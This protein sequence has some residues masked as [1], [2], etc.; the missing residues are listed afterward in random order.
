MLRLAS[1]RCTSVSRATRIEVLRDV[2]ALLQVPTTIARLPFQ[3]SPSSYPL[4][5][6]SLAGEHSSGRDV[7]IFGSADAG[8]EHDV[9][10][11]HRALKRRRRQG[12]AIQQPCPLVVMAP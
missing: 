3:F 4:E 6:T 8:R 7:G 11:A 9:A 10:R 5:C 1:L 2:V 12:H